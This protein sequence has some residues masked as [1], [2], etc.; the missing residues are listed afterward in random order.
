MGA[1][2]VLLRRRAGAPHVALVCVLALVALV[3]AAQPSLTGDTQRDAKLPLTFVANA[4]QTDSSVRYVAR[5]AGNSFYFTSDKVVLDF[6]RGR[7]GVALELRFR[8]ANPH[9]QIVAE[10][11]APG[12]FNYLVGS[13]RKTNLATYS[14]LRYR[15]LWPGI[16]MVFRGEGG[17][18]KYEFL[19]SPGADTRDIRLAYAGADSLALGEAGSLMIGTPLGP[20]RDQRPISRQ[21]RTAVDTRYAV[22][23]SSYGFAVG[24]YDRTRPL[25]IDPGLVWSTYLGG[26]DPDDTSRLAMDTGGNSYVTGE[27][28]SPDFPATPGAYDTALDGPWDVFVTKLSPGGA[29]VY[30][31]YLGGS[32][33]EGQ[34]GVAVDAAG[35]AYLGG[36]TSSSDF[37]TTPG[38][39]HSLEG[40]QDAFVAKLNAAGDDLV[41]STFLGGSAVENTVGGFAIDQTGHAYIT[42]QTNS[43]DFPLTGG[44][45]DTTLS[46]IEGFV[47]KLSDTGKSLE[48]STYL[49]GS[50]GEVPWDITVAG[51]GNAYVTGET[52]SSNFPTTP[53][54]YDT[55]HGATF[56]EAFVT[57]INAAGTAFDYSTLIGDGGGRSKA[58]AVD[59]TGN[60]YIAGDAGADWPTTPGAFDNGIPGYGDAFITKL[61]PAANALVYSSFLGS[62]G[63]GQGTDPADIELDGAGSAYIAGNTGRD[64]PTTPGAVDNTRAGVDAIVM[65]LNPA[66]SGLAYS[67]YLG[68][69]SADFAQGIALDGQGNVVVAGSTTSSDFPTTPGALQGSNAGS[70]DAF[71]TKLRPFDGYPRPKGAGPLYISLVTA[72][73]FRSCSSSQEMVHG[74][75]LAYSSCPPQMESDFL[76]VGTGD[77]NGLPARNDGYMRFDVLAGN[78]ATPADEADVKV[79]FFLDDIFN[80]DLTDYAGELRPTITVRITDR[81]GPESVMSTE[82]DFLLPFVAPC[83]PNPDSLEGSACTLTTTVDSII[84]GAIREGRRTIW[85]IEDLEVYD[86]GPDGDADTVPGQTLFARRGVFIP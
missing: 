60:A 8:G 27:T 17:S 44:A 5:D 47:T 20:L 71:A 79:G 37:P 33:T 9:P 83:T 59:A 29:L 34:N 32:G 3:L 24:G 85:R 56:G 84:P 72:Y 38:T 7:R 81:D 4:G 64:I 58:I 42:G 54:A 36:Y 66:G 69:T 18:L 74:P 51:A 16:D 75:P 53:G 76:T 77:S 40:S 61:N 6:Q 45:P 48:Y 31:T 41:Y 43:T 22:S 11:R 21:G 13:Q 68:G 67:T 52:D 73:K 57:K 15:D 49:G 1:A 46:G 80:K 62:R 50:Q 28:Q 12:H 23:G 30:S 26:V 19:V 55:T 86:G 70:D 82:Q 63:G 2:E 78:P 35:N 10:R 39:D 65:K 25:L 14:Q